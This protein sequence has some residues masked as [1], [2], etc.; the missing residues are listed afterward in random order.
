[1]MAANSAASTSRPRTRSE[2]WKLWPGADGGWPICPA[3]A[4]TFCSRIARAT[5]AA[6]ILRLAIRSG[7]SQIR[8]PNSEPNTRTSPT[9]LA[10]FSWSTI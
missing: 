2:Y 3:G 1:M 10:R 9:P 7:R 6:V 4:W 5:S 8:M